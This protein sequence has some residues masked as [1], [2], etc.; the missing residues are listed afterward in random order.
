[1]SLLERNQNAPQA[2]QGDLPVTSRYTSGIA[3]E[4]FFRALKEDGK[5]LSSRC[6]A[7]DLTYVP[8]RQF[9]E[10]CLAELVEWLDAGTK[11]EVYTFTL[12]YENLDGSIKEEPEVIAF[13]RMGDGGIV[14][15]LSEVNL[16]EIDIGMPVEA[17]F[18]PKAEREGTILDIQYFRPQVL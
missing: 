7:C 1:M 8:A 9:C 3:G 17:V 5:I 12:L 18:K 14:H 13:V 6:E 10:R 11:G 16:E 2:W 4:R 15:K